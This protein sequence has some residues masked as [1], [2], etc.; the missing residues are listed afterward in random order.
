MADEIK[1]TTNIT[2]ANGFLSRTIQNGQINVTQTTLGTHDGVQSIGTSAEAI[3][4]GDLTTP[5]VMHL[6]NLDATNYINYGTS[7]SQIF[8]LKTG[9]EAVIRISTGKTVFAIA[10]TAPVKISRV[11]F[12]D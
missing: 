11:I 1:V 7:T 5:G 12:D 4:T 3:T 9:E 8:K 6:R 10:N 2:Y